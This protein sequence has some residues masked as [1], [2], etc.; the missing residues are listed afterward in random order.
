MV[1]KRG[2]PSLERA[3]KNARRKGNKRAEEKLIRQSTPN[4]SKSV[5]GKVKR[6]TPEERRATFESQAFKSSESRLNQPEPTG[7]EGLGPRRSLEDAKGI[8][9]PTGSEPIEAKKGIFEKIAEI[10]QALSP[11]EK[12]RAQGIE[13]QTGTVPLIGTFGA[14]NMVA[15]IKGVHKIV[16][17]APKVGKAIPKITG[18]TKNVLKNTKSMK[19]VTDAVGKI[20][21]RQGKGVIA[22]EVALAAIG[23]Y[24]WNAHLTVD[25]LIGGYGLAAGD[26]VRDENTDAYNQVSGDYD[27]ALEDGLFNDLWD[28]MPGINIIHTSLEIVQGA[29]SQ[30]KVY[31]KAILDMIE[32]KQNGTSEEDFWRARDAEKAEQQRQITEDRLA[33]QKIFNDNERIAREEEREESGRFWAAQAAKERELEAADRKAIA[34]F[35]EMYRRKVKEIND[36]NRPSNL[37][38]GLL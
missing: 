1:L 22:F 17:I 3:L 21:K 13:V 6:A 25:N 12:L 2:D 38:F 28:F 9:V 15:P 26:M 33:Q 35:W 7:K 24:A 34:D 31:D 27:E 36:N 19:L 10:N 29:R 5:A 30:K 32:Q 16:K 8:P 4:I 37:K 20:I 11:A 18:T 14:G 23:S